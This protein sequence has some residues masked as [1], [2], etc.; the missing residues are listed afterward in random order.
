MNTSAAG[1]NL[2]GD[3]FNPYASEVKPSEGMLWQPMALS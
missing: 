1:G 2:V 3:F